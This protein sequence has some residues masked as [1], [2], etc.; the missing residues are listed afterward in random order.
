MDDIRQYASCLIH[1]R[2]A[3]LLLVCDNIIVSDEISTRLLES[4]DEEPRTIDLNLA[5]TLHLSST[6]DIILLKQFAN[7]C[8]LTDGLYMIECMSNGEWF[9]DGNDDLCT[10]AKSLHHER[11]FS[12]KQININWHG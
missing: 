12:I 7:S 10:S 1:R 3:S 11:I 2:L 6:D 5:L 8:H 4:M 9:T